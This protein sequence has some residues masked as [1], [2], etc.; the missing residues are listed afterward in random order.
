[1]SGYIVESRVSPAFRWRPV[2]A[3]PHGE[4]FPFDPTTR[5]LTFDTHEAAENA[6]TMIRRANA[7]EYRV[8]AWDDDEGRP[9]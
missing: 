9:A 1:M 6:A 7:G 8:N 5:V 2:T 3:R 4:P